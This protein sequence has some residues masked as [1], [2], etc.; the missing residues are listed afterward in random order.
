M[1]DT[2]RS[3]L[4]EGVAA[5]KSREYDEARRKL[6]RMFNYDPTLE[7]KIEAWYWLS[8][9][10]SNPKEQREFIEQILAHNPA[11][12]RARRRLAI[13]DGR[14]N[15]DRV[16][17]PDTLDRT[18][19]KGPHLSGA[20]RFT[21]PQCGGRMT[22]APDGQLLTCEYCESRQLMGQSGRGG[23]LQQD[24]IAAM[25]TRQGHIH[26]T[27]QQ[28]LVCEGCGANFLLAPDV[29][30]GECPYCASSH[31][32]KSQHTQELIPPGA[33]IPFSV[34]ERQ[35]KGLLR[36]W[37]RNRPPTGPYRVSPGI[38][39]YLPVWLF[40]MGGLVKWRADISRNR[41]WIQVEDFGLVLQNNLL[42]PATRRLSPAC[43]EE[44]QHYDLSDLKPYDPRYLSAW[45]AESYTV[46]V[47]DASL[48][49][50]QMA[51]QEQRERV[52]AARSESLRNLVL[53]SSQMMVDSF[54]LA[55]LPAWLTHIESGRQK[56]EVIINGQ[57][58]NIRAQS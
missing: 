27:A 31:V 28:L 11:D 20:D 32:V 41:Q 53:D 2:T 7:Q 14:L 21:C 23:S 19:P 52:I 13:L 33:L 10:S 58:G 9:V 56:S 30:T 45:M 25:A 1:S 29:L 34:D 55:L 44:L 49:A 39:I 37:L 5:A 16:I 50:R 57:N 48:I 42:V 6:E 17:S 12:P 18:Q 43:V 26:A 38:G 36:Q 46:N 22:F 51:L 3:L 8:E 47:G 4:V 24:F 35:A 15:P 54:Q 40:N